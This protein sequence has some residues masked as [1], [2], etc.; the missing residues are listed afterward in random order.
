[1][2]EKLLLLFRLRVGGHA[3]LEELTTRITHALGGF[4]IFAGNE[5]FLAE[6]TIDMEPAQTVAGTFLLERVA[7]A[8]GVDHTFLNGFS[9]DELETTFGIAG[10]CHHDSGGGR[11]CRECDRSRGRDIGR[12]LPCQTAESCQHSNESHDQQHLRVTITHVHDG[13]LSKI[14]EHELLVLAIPSMQ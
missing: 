2:P 14:K 13:L 10:A 12:L 7:V 1:M 3:L 4:R 6:L 8:V 11:F 5:L 9:L